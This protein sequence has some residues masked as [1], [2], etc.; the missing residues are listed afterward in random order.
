MEFGHLASVEYVPLEAI[1]KKLAS[2]FLLS[3]ISL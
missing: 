3:V 2:S 1:N